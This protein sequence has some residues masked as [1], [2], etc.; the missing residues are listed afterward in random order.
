MNP[1]II[2][3]VLVALGGA[4]AGGFKL[5]ADHEIASQAR[6]Q[7][8]I[9]EA[10]DAANATAAQAIATLKPKYTTIQGKV[11]HETSTNTV[12]AD[13]HQS[14]NGMRLV[15]QSLGGGAIAPDSGKLP[16]AD[17]TGK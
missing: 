8:H 5:G 10:V 14:V 2:I 9:A 4:G 13:C 6:E 12:Y 7:N 3:F 16:K 11:I 15:N 1:Y 17:T